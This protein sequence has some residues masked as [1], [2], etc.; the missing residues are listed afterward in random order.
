LLWPRRDEIYETHAQAV[1]LALVLAWA[2]ERSG[3]PAAAR[4]AY[5]LA[6]EQLTATVD[7]RPDDF[8]IVMA[9]GL[10]SAGLGDREAARRHGER[11]LALN[12]VANDAWSS[13]IM[14]RNLLILQAASG[15]VEAALATLSTLL[16]A[17]NPGLSPALARL[18]P[19]L[20]GLREDPRFELVVARAEAAHP[21]P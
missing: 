1:P 19:R 21:I 17:P 8:R 6:G 11:A 16:A 2:H 4:Q 15:D 14:Q 5:R 13:P 20:D 7:R 9:L 12:P 10:V 3:D 18:E